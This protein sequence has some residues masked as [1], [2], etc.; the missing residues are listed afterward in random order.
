MSAFRRPEGTFAEEDI[1]MQI[2]AKTR[3]AVVLKF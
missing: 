2:R 1:C 3:N